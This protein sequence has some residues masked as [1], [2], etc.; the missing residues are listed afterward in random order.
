MHQHQAEF[1]KSSLPPVN[2][3]WSITLHDEASFQVGKP[4][5]G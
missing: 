1:D 2:A 4:G 3:F 5:Q